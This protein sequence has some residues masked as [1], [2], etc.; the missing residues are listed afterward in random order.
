M[1]CP[2]IHYAAIAVSRGGMGPGCWSVKPLHPACRTARGSACLSAPTNLSEYCTTPEN[3]LKPGQTGLLT[4]ISEQLGIYDSYFSGNQKPRKTLT[5][6]AL[7]AVVNR[8]GRRLRLQ[9]FLLLLLRD[10]QNCPEQPAS[11]PV[12]GY[13]SEIGGL[14]DGCPLAH[15]HHREAG[16]LGHDAPAILYSQPI[17]L[18]RM[19]PPSSAHHPA[20]GL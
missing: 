7:P 2:Y 19:C 3:S 13:L 11:V 17:M 8:L 18:T 1:N 5:P 15:G 6:S 20:Y 16:T 12:L 9:A 10:A 14:T 4:P